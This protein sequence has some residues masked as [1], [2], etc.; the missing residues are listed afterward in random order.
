MAAEGGLPLAAVVASAWIV[1]LAVL[2][3]GIRSRRRDLI[4]PIAAFSV[5][6]ISVLH[7]LVD[8]SLQ[9]PGYAIVVFALIGA[10]LAQSFGSNGRRSDQA[11]RTVKAA[12]S[13]G[14]SKI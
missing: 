5:A 12:K 6:I 7:A 3:N 14:K 9:I 13:Q 8:F 4:V 2:L 10:G 1:I 11:F